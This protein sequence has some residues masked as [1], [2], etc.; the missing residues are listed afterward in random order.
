MVVVLLLD[1]GGDDLR[2]GGGR[3]GGAGGDGGFS[4]F[5]EM[6]RTKRISW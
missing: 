3:T 4:R 5:V 6:E 2:H 1:V